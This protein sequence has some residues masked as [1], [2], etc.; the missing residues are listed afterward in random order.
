MRLFTITRLDGLVIT[1]DWD[2]AQGQFNERVSGELMLAA[3]AD[4]L[5]VYRE[6]L[7]VVVEPASLV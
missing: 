3:T 6:L 7:E 5:P 2:A 4:L 1:A